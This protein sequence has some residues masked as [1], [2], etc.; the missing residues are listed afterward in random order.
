MAAL[1]GS[2]TEGNLKAAFAA[3]S[4]PNRRYLHFAQKADVEGC[5]DTDVYPGMARNAPDEGFGE[6][7]DWFETLAKAERAHANR[8]IKALNE[9]E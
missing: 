9:L 2:G 1:E 7:A 5:S 4:Q 8:F 3:E 6:I